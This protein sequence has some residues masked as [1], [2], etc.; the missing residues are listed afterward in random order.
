MNQDCLIVFVLDQSG[1]MTN[2]RPETC[3][4]YNQFIEDQLKVDGQTLVTLTLFDTLTET[5]FVAQEAST[6]PS[7]GSKDNPYT[8]KGMTSLFDAVGDAVK[9]TEEWITVSKWQGQVKVVVL[10]DGEENS[11]S[12]WH[13]NNPRKDNDDRD[14]AGLIEWKQN[15][16]WDFVFLGAGGTQWLER[17]FNTLDN[18]VFYA[19][20]GGAQATMDCHNLLSA[21]VTRSRM[22]GNSVGSTMQ[23]DADPT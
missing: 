6:I 20:A 7:L 12:R 9:K 10:T 16:G 21:S 18:N 19:Y 11:S 3:A 4:G 2:V 23:Q 5:P 22:T 13:I 15:E 1:S 8:P 14:I 17:T